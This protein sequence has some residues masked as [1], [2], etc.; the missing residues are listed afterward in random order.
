MQL[1]N[2]NLQ[3][4][5]MEPAHLFPQD[6]KKII[7]IIIFFSSCNSESQPPR[8]Q[9]GARSYLLSSL[10]FLLPFHHVTM[11]NL[12]LQDCTM[13]LAW[14]ITTP[15]L[16]ISP[17]FTSWNNSAKPRPPRPRYGACS[18]LP[19][20]LKFLPPFHHASLQSQPSRLQYG[21]THH[22]YPQGSNL[23]SFSSWNSRILTFKATMC[24]QIVSTSKISHHPFSSCKKNL[25]FQGCN[26]ELVPFFL[27][28]LT[29]SS[30][31][32]MQP[33]NLNL[34]GCKVE[35]PNVTSSY[36]SRMWPQTYMLT[37]CVLFFIATAAHIVAIAC[38]KACKVIYF[39][40]F[41]Y[42]HVFAKM[43]MFFFLGFYVCRQ[44]NLFP[45]HHRK[46]LGVY[47]KLARE[48]VNVESA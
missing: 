10:Q 5:S 15:E 35:L 44:H 13:E 14:L 36:I 18:C 23:S 45:S 12:N 22:A 43:N 27:Q 38:T 33:W 39:S 20:S 47:V 29:L 26:M 34:K 24:S 37:G 40:Y 9:Y 25:N 32:I 6:F 17:P 2:F 46:W 4:Y 42:V 28:N 16:R 41:R 3:I 30:L 11:H 8:M 21:A 1:C 31:F 19:T 7:I 48:V